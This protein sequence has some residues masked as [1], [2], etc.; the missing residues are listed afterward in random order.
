[1]LASN[2]F[3]RRTRDD[4][5]IAIAGSLHDAPTLGK[6]VKVARDAAE[7]GKNPDAPLGESGRAELIRLRAESRDGRSAIAELRMQAEFAKKRV[8]HERGRSHEVARRLNAARTG[9][10]LARTSTRRLT[11]WGS[12][13]GPGAMPRRLI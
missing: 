12:R 5:A 2:D 1:M 3:C 13:S 10:G 7:S 6:W 9:S 11:S 8:C 4:S